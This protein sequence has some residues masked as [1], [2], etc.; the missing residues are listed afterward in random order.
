VIR[1]LLVEVAD[2]GRWGDP[3]RTLPE[4]G[5]VADTA[6]GLELFAGVEGVQRHPA[7]LLR[8]TGS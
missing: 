5:E 2:D 1:C 3:R 8:I 4:L 6:G 7:R